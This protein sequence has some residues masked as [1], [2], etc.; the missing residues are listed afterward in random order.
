[1]TE[2][3]E[4]LDRTAA[5][6]PIFAVATHSYF[7]YTDLET[8]LICN[9]GYY[10]GTCIMHGSSVLTA[11]RVDPQ[12]KQSPTLFE[13]YQGVKC[14]SRVFSGK[15]QNIH[16]IARWGDGNYICNTLHNEL[17]WIAFDG[18]STHSFKVTDEDQSYLNSVYPTEDAVWITLRHNDTVNSEIIKLSHG[19]E[20]VELDRFRAEHR[21]IHDLY[22]ES[23]EILYY[24][25]S[26]DGKVVRRVTT[27]GSTYWNEL[28]VG[29]HPKG[30]QEHE[31]YLYVGVSEHAISRERRFTSDGK[32]AVINLADWRLEDMF[33]LRLDDQT[34]GS[35][36]DIRYVSTGKL[37][38]NE[39]S[40][41][42]IDK[43]VK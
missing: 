26:N 14:I 27:N 20:Y 10:T 33:N 7:L 2:S 16:Q 3:R 35:I 8:T 18:E 1:M 43:S 37:T 11:K 28:V 19:P 22:V 15:I 21:G 25:A 29:G 9:S 42:V 36:N 5:T 31:G 13:H 4:Q 38:L 30:M 32:I 12:S 39:G 6:R 41:H 17:Q 40:I 34:V 23:D 24:N